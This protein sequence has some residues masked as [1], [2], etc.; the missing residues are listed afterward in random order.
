VVPLVNF[1]SQVYTTTLSIGRNPLFSTPTPMQVLYAGPA[2][3]LVSGVCQIDVVIP[4][5]TPPGENY[6]VIV[7]GPGTSPAIPVYVQ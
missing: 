7:T 5:G 1:P 4:A 2:P 6:V 3:G